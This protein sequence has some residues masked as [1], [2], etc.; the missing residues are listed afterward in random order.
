MTRSRGGMARVRVLS[1]LLLL[2]LAPLGVRAAAEGNP[3]TVPTAATDA[4]QAELAGVARPLLERRWFEY[5]TAA[6]TLYSDLD[7]KAALASVR[8]IERFAHVVRETVGLAQRASVI[9][10]EFWLCTDASAVARLAGDSTLLGFMRPSPRASYL[11]ATASALDDPDGSPMLH[12]YVHLL[13]RSAARATGSADDGRHDDGR[14]DDGMVLDLPRWYDEGLAE[15]LATLRVRD[16]EVRIGV[17]NRRRLAQLRMRDA[18]LMGIGQVLGTSAVEALPGPRV[19]EFYALSW[20]LVHWSYARSWAQGWPRDG[21]GPG[22]RN[23]AIDD[24]LRRVSRGEPV[25]AAARAAF[26]VDVQGLQRRL[27]EHVDR[28]RPVPLVKLPA[29]HFARLDAAAPVTPRALDGYEAAWRLGYV[30]LG[31]GRSGAQAGAGDEAMARALFTHALRL[32]PGDLRAQMGL[33]VADQFEQRFAEGVAL[34]RAVH[35]VAPDDTLLAQELA[36]MLYEWCDSDTPPPHCPRLHAEA[37]ALY[38]RI[39]RVAPDRIETHAA[40]GGALLDARGDAA[41]ARGHLHRAHAAMPFSAHL[42]LQLGRAELRLGNH[43][44]AERL[45]RRAARWSETRGMAR[46]VQRAL[47]ELGCVEPPSRSSRPLPGDA[48]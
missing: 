34:A 41:R 27:L 46:R 1:L 22:A 35:A 29:A 6:F 19:A 36:D 25:R 15:F 40:L 30:A 21:Q 5:R 11:V 45:L 16:G 7:A 37:I 28:V 42:V 4:Y 43:A 47:A 17:P 12:E 20:A 23:L 39:L 3:T 10:V 13:V 18:R 48:C 31:G 9:P 44:A 8:D 24:Y 32:R 26:G 33:A 2:A 38:E 14:H